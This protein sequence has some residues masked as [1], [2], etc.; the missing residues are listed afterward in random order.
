MVFPNCWGGVS[1]LDAKATT[2]TKVAVC[3]PYFQQVAGPLLGAMLLLMGIAP[4]LP[5]RRASRENLAHGFGWPIGATLAGSALLL[6][7]GSRNVFAVLGFG[8]CLLVL[9][10]VL[11]E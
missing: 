9:A 6:G 5:W 3:P 10:T 8:L 2:D 1:P 7:L 4:L 11:Q